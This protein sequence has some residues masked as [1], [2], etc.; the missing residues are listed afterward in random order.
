MLSTYKKSHLEKIIALYIA[1]NPKIVTFCFGKKRPIF[2]SKYLEVNRDRTDGTRR[3]RF[4]DAAI[5]YLKNAQPKDVSSYSS[6]EFEIIWI[7]RSGEK[8][9]MHIREESI[10][11]DKKL[12]LISTFEK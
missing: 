12:F 10:Q 9:A 1:Q 8:F 7:T 11:K 2:L 5:R 4:F 6:T 3:L